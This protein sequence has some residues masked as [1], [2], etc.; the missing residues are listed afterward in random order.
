ME[1]F[2]EPAGAKAS[3][4]AAL[5]LARETVEV[6]DPVNKRKVIRYKDD[7]EKELY[8]HLYEHLDINLMEPGA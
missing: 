4:D 7:I 1:Y 6:W 5:P 8:G 2:Y 3:I